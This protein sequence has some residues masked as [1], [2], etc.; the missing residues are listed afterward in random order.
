MKARRFLII[1]AL[2][3]GL[4]AACQPVTAGVL[5]ETGGE[6]AQENQSLGS[7]PAAPQRLPGPYYSY[8]GD[9]AYDPAA[10]G[11]NL[12]Q[13][14]SD[15]VKGQPVRKSGGY[16]GD[17]AYDTAAGGL[18][19]KQKQPVTDMEKDFFNKGSYSGDDPYDPAA[20]GLSLDR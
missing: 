10:G 4:L 12:G 2:G 15:I 7:V 13:R 14:P 19:L 8:S 5:V 3:F 1:L 18:S 11:L 17:D 6:G 20:G 16:S 9:D